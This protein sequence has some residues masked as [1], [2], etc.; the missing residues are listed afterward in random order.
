MFAYGTTHGDRFGGAG[1]RRIHP[2]GATPLST[3][4]FLT[5][6]S[7]AVADSVT[8]NKSQVNPAS[9][10]VGTH[11]DT[12]GRKHMTKAYFTFDLSQLTGHELLSASFETKE[13]RLPT[14]PSCPHRRPG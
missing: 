3:P 4:A 13:Q 9:A 14:A 11:V 8:P 7:S 6:T 5:S 10:P 1:R 2:V 12:A